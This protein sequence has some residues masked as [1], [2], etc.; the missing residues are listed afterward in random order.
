MLSTLTL[1]LIENYKFHNVVLSFAKN[2]AGCTGVELEDQL[3]LSLSIWNLDVK[4]L[5]VI[6]TDICDE[7]ANDARPTEPTND[8]LFVSTRPFIG[9]Y[10]L[11][12]SSVPLGEFAYHD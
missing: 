10:P 12:S 6:V 4:R 8:I 3:Y 7:I 5:S 2:K 9:I 11:F 1:H